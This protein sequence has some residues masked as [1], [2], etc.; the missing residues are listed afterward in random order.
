MTPNKILTNASLAICS[1]IS[2]DVFAQVDT[3]SESYK[4][5]N[6]VGKIL[7]YIFFGVIVVMVIKKFLK[8]KF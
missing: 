2:I 4:S 1:I 6:S 5:G 8:N 3:A 7:G